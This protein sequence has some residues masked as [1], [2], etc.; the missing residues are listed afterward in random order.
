[1]QTEADLNPTFDP[2]EA[3]RPMKLYFTY[4]VRVSNIG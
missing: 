2:E 1:M 3:A 4:R